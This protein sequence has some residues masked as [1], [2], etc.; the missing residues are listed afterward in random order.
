[1]LERL[2]IGVAF[3]WTHGAVDTHSSTQTHEHPHT[4]S[5]KHTHTHTLPGGWSS[6]SADPDVTYSWLS[7]APAWPDGHARW[8]EGLV[9]KCL[10]VEWSK[11]RLVACHFEPSIRQWRS[12]IL[13]PSP[14][15][16]WVS[17]LKCTRARLSRPSINAGSHT[18]CSASP[19]AYT[20]V[21]ALVFVCVCVL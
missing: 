21:R 18:I 13:L 7:Q 3:C 16:T 20:F 2:G 10:G 9:M 17:V 1:M 11:R 6:V 14:C 8:M 19:H 4:H 5:T 12:I 15:V